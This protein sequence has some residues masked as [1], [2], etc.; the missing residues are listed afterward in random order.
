[1]NKLRTT[2]L[3][4]LIVG[5]FLFLSRD[6]KYFLQ[7]DA[8]IF[9]RYAHNLAHGDGFVYNPGERV[10]GATSILWTLMGAFGALFTNE[11]P[12]LFQG[13]SLLF[14]LLWLAVFALFCRR[15]ITDELAWVLPVLLM[16][17]YPSFWLWSYGGLETPF[18]GFLMY[19]GFLLATDWHERGGNYRLWLLSLVAV[20]LILTRP[21]GF[22]VSL[23]LLGFVVIFPSQ[24]LRKRGFLLLGLSVFCAFFGLMLFRYQYFGDWVPNTYYAKGGGGY[25]LKRYG[26]GRLHSFFRDYFNFLPVFF[27]LLGFLVKS[28]LRYWLLIIPGWFF[29]FVWVGGDILPENRLMLPAIPMLFLGALVFIENWGNA[30]R[31]FLI[32]PTFLSL[33]LAVFLSVNYYSYYKKSLIAYTGVLPALGNAHIAAGKYLEKNMLPGQKALLT[34]AGA[35]AYY[36]PSHF[37]TD[38]LGLCDRTVGRALYESGYNPWATMYCRDPLEAALRRSALFAELDR[39]FRQINPD[40]LVLNIYT[41]SDAETQTIMK[42][43]QAELPDTLPDFII[44]HVSLEGYFGIMDSAEDGKGWK[45][46]FLGSFSPMFWM[47]IAK[48]TSPEGDA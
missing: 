2:F 44:R 12:L 34:D 23:F 37:F 21:E 18:F 38:W 39:Y 46:V 25:Y 15:W 1:M 6:C 19:S 3:F 22:P 40:Y 36:A 28:K 11:L 20:G 29:Y 27:S 16:A 17:M 7:D 47:V 32:S 24:G 8:F 43:Y 26:L 5:L 45:P 48:K 14:S 13:M 42:G 33:L 4:G 30:F 10:E 31:R 35:T 9:A 41:D